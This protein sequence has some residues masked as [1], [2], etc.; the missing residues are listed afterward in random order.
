MN[1]LKLILIPLLLISCSKKEQKLQPL[2]ERQLESFQ[3]S[4]VQANSLLV[5][6]ARDGMPVAGTTILIGTEA[7]KEFQ[8]NLLSTDENGMAA[9]P[10]GWTESLAVTADKPGFVTQTHLNKTPQSFVLQIQPIPQSINQYPITGSVDGFGNLKKDGF[11]DFALVVPSFTRE[12]LLNIDLSKMI[13]PELEAISVLGF[14]FN[15]PSNIY[16]PRQTESYS[17]IPFSLEKPLFKIF[18]D[19][20]GSHFV[21]A[22][23]GRFDFKKVAETIKSGKTYFEVVNDFQFASYGVHS[24]EVVNN[25]PKL[26]LATATLLKQSVTFNPSVNVSNRLLY[27]LAVTEQQNSYSVVDIKIKS[28]PAPKLLFPE[29][30]I[31]QIL[32]VNVEIEKAPNNV[33]KIA[34]SMSTA[35]VAENQVA[36][37]VLLDPITK[38]E[39]IDRG[40]QATAPIA[41][42]GVT[43]HSTRIYLSDLDVQM[44][45]DYYVERKTVQWEIFSEGWITKA[46]LPQLGAH[47]KTLFKRWDV[48][49]FGQAEGAKDATHMVRNAVNFN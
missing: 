37:A 11:I 48:I 35:L 46:Q 10:E 13:S 18:F 8:G 42:P 36:K 20:P 39:N 17:F 40:V 5:V 47:D 27:G 7:N 1:L 43:P 25:T 49:Y 29:N 38:P 2:T 32:L 15:L 12:S 31:K 34:D 45:P 44:T 41:K 33:N 24:L 30:T 22:N 23:R 14:T 9:I 16:L 21:S 4:A 28:S 19:F 3:K 6:N 26:K